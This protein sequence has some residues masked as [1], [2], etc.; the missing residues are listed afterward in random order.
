M[1]PCRDHRVFAFAVLAVLLGAACGGSE[2]PTG[3]GSSS[4]DPNDRPVLYVAHGGGK[5]RAGQLSAYEIDPASGALSTIAG[6]PITLGTVAPP[7]RAE[8]SNPQ[9]LALHPKQ[10]FV[11]VPA[12]F[13]GLWGARLDGQSGALSLI[14]G[15]P[16]LTTG[17]PAF[18]AVESSG[19][20][21]YTADPTLEVCLL[22]TSPSPRD[23]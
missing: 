10:P 6:S 13:G 9:A 12:A 14:P 22:Y 17:E 8:T 3:T 23:S 7:G 19:R 1:K 2:D 5:D 16:L 15:L 18:A 20:F 11:Y 21:L 4:P